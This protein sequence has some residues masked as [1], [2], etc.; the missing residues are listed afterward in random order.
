M[1]LRWW[2]CERRIKPSERWPIFER[3]AAI[4]M[5]ALAI[6][7]R[8]NSV[9]KAWLFYIVLSC[10]R[11]NNSNNEP[12]SIELNYPAN[13]REAIDLSKSTCDYCNN[14][15]FQY[16]IFYTYTQHKHTHT[17][18]YT[19]FD[20]FRIVFLLPIRCTVDSS[21]NSTNIDLIQSYYYY[22]IR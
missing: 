10:C 11:L 13:R 9:S 14:I 1:T 20:P 4:T 19:F 12:S 2:W 6:R 22:Y 15:L 17:Y 3:A 5:R 18:I 8:W 16:S 21:N 7:Q